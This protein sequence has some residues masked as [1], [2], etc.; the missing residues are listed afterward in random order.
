[1]EKEMTKFERVNAVM[2]VREPDTVPVYPYILTHGVYANEWRLPEITTQ[3]KLDVKMSTQCVFKT[4]QEYDYDMAIGSYIDLYFG[5]TELG[6]KI[7]IPDKYG[8][9]VS[10]AEA[11]VKEPGDWDKVS[12][13]FPLDPRAGGRMKDVLDSYKIVSEKIGKTTPIIPCWWPG[14]TSAMCLLRGPEA[15]TMDMALDPNFAHELI[16]A[17]NDFT[18]DFLRGMYENGANSVTHL[19]DIYGT[20][21]LS[22]DQCK[23]FVVPYVGKIS[24][25]IYEEFGQKTWLHVHGDFMSEETY[26]VLKEFVETS[27][28]AGFHPDEKHP[29]EFLQDKVKKVYNIAVAGIIHGPGPLLNG[30][31]DAIEATTK[32]IIDAAAEGGGLMIAPS[33]EVPPDTPPENFK[34]WVQV[35]HEYGAYN[36][37]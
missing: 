28:V 5:V 30:P 3:T 14:P 36:G 26:P 17:A 20:E 4:L 9:V 7:K 1:M 21:M 8:G 22:P 6:G 34:K 37:R 12:K 11:P 13:M 10:M 29:P 33:C 35:T 19:G 24:R 15:L 18:I 25:T 27:R 31:L 32:N 2:E 16:K 23:E